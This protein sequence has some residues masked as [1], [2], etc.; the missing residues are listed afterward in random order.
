[1]FSAESLRNIGYGTLTGLLMFA[2]IVIICWFL[3]ERT[4]RKK[5]REKEKERKEREIKQ[6]KT[7]E[8]AEYNRGNKVE[9]I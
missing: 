9:G 5:E 4:E 8:K 6:K 1:M 3:R 7:K 2:I